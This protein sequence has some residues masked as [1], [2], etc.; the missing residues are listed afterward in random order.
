MWIRPSD[1][2]DARR[3]TRTG[4]T[5]MELLI[6]LTIGAFVLSAAISFLITQL[7]TLE[8][9]D[10]RDEVARN[11]RYIGISLRRDVQT[12]GIEITSTTRFGT[13]T[14][15]SGSPGDTLVMLHVP[16][17]PEPAPAHDI[18]P[19]P[20]TDNPLP[21]GGTCGERCIDVVTDPEVPLE[22]QVGDLA[23]LQVAEERRLILIETIEETT[24]T[25][26]AITWND[27]DSLL[28]QPAGLTGGLRLDRYGTYVQKLQPIIYYLNEGGF[29]MRAVRLNMDGSPDGWVLAFNVQNFDAS[30][31]FSDGDVLDEANPYDSDDSNDYDDI[32]GVRIVATVEADRA[33]PRVNQGELIR[34]TFEWKIAP[35]NLRYEKNRY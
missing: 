32:M 1:P 2:V 10:I 17:N 24:D 9:S 21:A 28:R 7:R 12:A 6:A 3:L 35:R 22:L 23:R 14:V 27:A 11:A 13:M 4:Y 29:L 18:A 31:I 8:G 25:S 30:L 34:K 15:W 26:V 33:D 19:E 16:S 5:L 20:G